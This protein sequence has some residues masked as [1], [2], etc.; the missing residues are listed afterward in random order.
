MEVSPLTQDN[1]PTSFQPK[2]VQ[3]YDILFREDGD[4]TTSDGFWQEF[5][6]LK[7][8]KTRLQERLK[9]LSGHDLLHLQVI[10]SLFC[11]WIVARD[12]IS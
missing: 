1:R 7:P 6:L 8:D 12:L 11:Y 2:I 5:F 3:L 4:A 9:G 10:L